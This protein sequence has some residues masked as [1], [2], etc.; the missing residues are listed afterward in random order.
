MYFTVSYTKTNKENSFQKL[1]GNIDYN[2]LGNVERREEEVEK[3]WLTL[4]NMVT[5]DCYLVYFRYIT[6]TG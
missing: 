2:R 5:A 3:H 1:R 4:N 6:K